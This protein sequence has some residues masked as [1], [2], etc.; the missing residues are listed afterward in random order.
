MAILKELRQFFFRNS[1]NSIEFQE[2]PSRLNWHPHKAVNLEM[3]TSNPLPVYL[4]KTSWDYSK[5]TECDNTLNNWKMIFQ[6]SDGIGNQFFNLLNDNFNIIEPFY[7]KGRSQLQVFGHSNLLCV[8][9]SR[10]ITN[11]TLIGEYRLRFFSREEFKCP[12][13]LYSIKL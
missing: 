11:H 2:C 4:C 6:A 12:C 9:A 8:H 13:G 1:N 5:K 3:K 7:A 10:A